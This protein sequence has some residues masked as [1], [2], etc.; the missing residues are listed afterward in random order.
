MTERMLFGVAALVLVLDQ[1]SS[2][3][4]ATMETPHRPISAE[5]L[6]LMAIQLLDQR[7]AERCWDCCEADLEFRFD[8]AEA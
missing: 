2:V 5:E 4:G 3:G 8:L 1:G 7:W 6:I